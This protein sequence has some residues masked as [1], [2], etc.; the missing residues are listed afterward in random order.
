[1]RACGILTYRYRAYEDA[2][3]AIFLSLHIG[4]GSG[5]L[6]ALHDVGGVFDRWGFV[7]AG[8]PM[9]QARPAHPPR[10]ARPTPPL[11]P[12]RRLCADYGR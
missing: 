11:S 12:R 6:S 8:P 9:E 7:L 3:G 10:P 4:V 2:S 5:T 1:M